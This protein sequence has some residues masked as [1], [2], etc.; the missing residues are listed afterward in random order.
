[1]PVLKFGQHLKQHAKSVLNQCLDE[2]E[3]KAADAAENSQQQSRGN[4]P[5]CVKDEELGYL[6]VH[7]IAL[8]NPHKVPYRPLHKLPVPKRERKGGRNKRFHHEEDSQ[9]GDPRVNLERRLVK[10]LE[11]QQRQ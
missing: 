5:P 10:S 1:M 7:V 4:Y 2:L 3:K 8:P 9:G 6:G 11:Q